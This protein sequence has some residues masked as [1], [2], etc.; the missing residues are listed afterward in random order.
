MFP[1][2]EC[3]GPI[4]WWSPDPRMVLFPD[5]FHCSRRLARRMRQGHLRLSTDSDFAGVMHGCAD[6]PEGTWIHAGMLAAYQRLFDAGYAHSIEV[7][8]AGVLVGGLYGVR[9]GGVFFAESMFSRVTDASKM[10]MAHLVRLAEDKA[11]AMIDCQFHT[12]HL[13]SLGAVEICREDFLRRL[14]EAV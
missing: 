7:R 4:L 8:Q 13:L 2:Y 5:A 9:I 10:A 3:E 6:R 14:A 1:W 12:A 11:W